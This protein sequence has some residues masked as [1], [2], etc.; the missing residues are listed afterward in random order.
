VPERVVPE[1]VVPERVVPERVVVFGAGGP[2]ASAFVTHAER[3]HVLRLVDIRPLGEI[4]AE[5][6]PFGP[7]APLPRLLGAPHEIRV[8]DITNLESV[9]EMVEGMEAIVNLT[10]MRN[11]PVEAF[12]VNVLGPYNVMR[13]A[14][15]K[16]IGKV[17]LSGPSQISMGGPAGY[18]YDDEALG[19]DVPARPGT[20]LYYV[21]KLL[22]QQIGRVFAQ[23][24][25]IEAPCLLI[26][27]LL[28]PD[29]E[30]RPPNVP[31]GAYPFSVSWMDAGLAVHQAL[32]AGH[33]P[34]WFEPLF[35]VGDVPHGRFS[36]EK[37]KWLLGWE[38]R[39]RLEKHWLREHVPQVGA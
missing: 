16:G 21:S 9:M 36:N 6:K 32:R 25:G 22:G 30:K 24:R 5:G 33:M 31:H 2:I 7:G 17:V 3:D 39:D 28:N 15:A 1:R 27:P 19:P 38:P 4:V 13:A 34:R 18:T 35:V 29:P 20:E 14:V 10:A 8:G 12:R 26:G 11:D 37:T 23:E